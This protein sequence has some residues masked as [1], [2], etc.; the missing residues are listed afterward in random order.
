MRDF[1]AMK[2]LR[3]LNNLSHC[4]FLLGSES[5]KL[6]LWTSVSC[7]DCSLG[8]FKELLIMLDVI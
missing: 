3:R 1:E 5:N 8:E 6:T 2:A 4:V 7:L